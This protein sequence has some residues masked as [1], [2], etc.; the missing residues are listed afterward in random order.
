IDSGN[1]EMRQLDLVV[2]DVRMPGLSGLDVVRVLRSWRWATPVLFV[3]AYPDQRFLEQASDLGAT[4]LAKPF[5]LSR[6]SRVASDTL[7]GRWS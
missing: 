2:I 7:A 4:V 1:T 5:V 6:L 3:T